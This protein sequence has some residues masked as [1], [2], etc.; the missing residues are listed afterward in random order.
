MTQD[1]VLKRWESLS[2]RERDCWVAKA[3]MGW[4]EIGVFDNYYV[5][6]ERGHRGG[7]C[8]GLPQKFPY[9]RG[10]IPSDW[11][12][13]TEIADAWDVVEHFK[14]KF[15]EIGVSH[16]G[17]PTEWWDCLIFAS[18]GSSRV[19]AREGAPTT[20]ESICKTAITAIAGNY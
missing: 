10:L 5:F 20:P 13:S 16:S 18:H 6:R 9:G 1:E 3:V 4:P 7:I 11:R 19:L 14:K 12:P 8:D 17:C 15:H 2:P